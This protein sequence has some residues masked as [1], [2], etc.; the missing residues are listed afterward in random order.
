MKLL[1]PTHI[2]YLSHR[3]QLLI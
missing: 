3:K 2:R 1:I